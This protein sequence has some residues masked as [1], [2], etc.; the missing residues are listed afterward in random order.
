MENYALPNEISHA[1]RTVLVMN[2]N[3]PSNEWFLRGYKPLAKVHELK[4][5]TVKIKI[6]F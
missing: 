3:H 6:L 5:G 1:L 2:H 4:I